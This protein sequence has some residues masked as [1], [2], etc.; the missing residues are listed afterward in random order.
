MTLPNLV[1]RPERLTAFPPFVQ[2]GCVLHNFCVD[3]DQALIQAAL[4]A[5]FK[6]PSNGAVSYTAIGSKLFLSVA[7][8]AR[9]TSLDPGDSRRG[10][11]QEIDVTVWVMAC[12]TGTLDLR[13]I[14][15]WL[16]VDSAPAMATGR[17]VYGFPK[18]IGRFDFSPQD[19]PARRFSTQAFAIAT[20]TPES[21]AAWAPIIEFEPIVAGPPPPGGTVLKDL[22]ALAAHAVARLREGVTG[23]ESG[24]L[25]AVSGAMAG[26]GG[27][28]GFLKQFPDAQ[29]PR[30]A[31]Y[32]AIVEADCK[33]IGAPNVTLTPQPY[34]A[35]IHSYASHPLAAQLGIAEGWQDIG[36]AVVVHFD[37]SIGLGRNV[38]VAGA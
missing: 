21:H 7:E 23:I 9:I 29:D 2:S 35:N 24:L 6:T 30:L 28:L 18:Q 5:T 15:L 16:F 1:Q 11:M 34:R 14:P 20:Y 25:N 33:V 31:C 37:F 12:V 32:Q 13:W 4:D 10:W 8:I 38:W 3:G 26:G 27:V 19:D 22:E 36:H 17:E